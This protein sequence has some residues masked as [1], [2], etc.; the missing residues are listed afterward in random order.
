MPQA[1]NFW[2]SMTVT[3]HHDCHP[4]AP[5][6]LPLLPPSSKTT[7]PPPRIPLHHLTPHHCCHC[8]CCC[9]Y[10]WWTLPLLLPLSCFLNTFH[11]FYQHPPC[12]PP[13]PLTPFTPY[14]PPPHL[15]EDD[16]LVDTQAARLSNVINNILAV[17]QPCS[18]SSSSRS[19]TRITTPQPCPAAAQHTL[20]CSPCK[21]MTPTCSCYVVPCFGVLCCAPPPTHTPVDARHGWDGLVLVSL[22]HKDGQDEVGG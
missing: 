12:V 4:L 2:A 18:S 10:H 3:L 13:S 21:Q 11:P 8:R 9:L 7:P 6:P 16:H 17:R 14:S 20:L 5:H 15:G 19:V 1:D 22:V